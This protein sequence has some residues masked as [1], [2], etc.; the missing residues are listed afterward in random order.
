MT[1]KPKRSA[2]ESLNV[3]QLRAEVRAAWIKACEAEG[4]SVDAKF[5][6]FGNTVEA[7]LYN[8]LAGFLLRAL[9]AQ[10]Q[11]QLAEVR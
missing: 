7:A 4:I 8:E 6:V 1:I 11:N 5:V 9:R 10:K 3:P 2:L